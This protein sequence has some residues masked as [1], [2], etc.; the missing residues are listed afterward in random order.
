MTGLQIAHYR[1]DKLIGRGGMGEV[2]LAYDLRLDRPVAIKVLPERKRDSDPAVS[3]FLREAKAASALNHPNIVTIHEV[4]ETE[5]GGHFMVQELVDGE[6][7]RVR[8]R[9][10]KKLALDAV[11]DIGR[12]TARALTAAHAHGII[13]RDIKPENLMV[14]RDGYVKVLDFGLARVTTTEATRDGESEFGT[15]PG[16]ILGT[17]AYMSPEQ[18]RGEP[19]DAASDIFTLGILLYEIATGHRPFSVESG[20]AQLHAIVRL[21]PLAPSRHN[22]E[23]PTTFDGLILRMLAKDKAMRPTADEVARELDAL[24]GQDRP[25]AAATAVAARRRTVGREKERDALRHAFAEMTA[26][27]GC[28]AALAG[29]PGIGKTS[30]AEDF[31]AEIAAGPHHPVIARG[32]CSERLAGTE[33]YMPILEALDNLIHGGSGEAFTS[34]L[35]QTAPVWFVQVAPLSTESTTALQ[36]HEDV[37]SASQERMKRELGVLLQEISRVRPVVLFLEDLHWA[38][39]S[40]IDVLNYLGGRLSGMRVMVLVTYRPSEMMLA[41]HPYL[42]IRSDLEASGVLRDLPL[43]FLTR[44]DVDHYL[45]LEFPE[46]RFVPDFGALVYS[47]TEGSPLFMVDLLRYL[48]DRGA[49]IQNDGRW[50]LA[51]SIAE[52]E[53]ELPDSVRATIERKIERLDERDRKL[54]VAAAVQGHEFDSAIVAD[55][56]GADPADVEEQLDDLVRV[57]AMIRKVEDREL[58]DHTL[59]VRC[60]FVHVLYQ[61][62]LYASLQPTRR[63]SLS[64]KVA[65]SMVTHAGDKDRALASELAMLFETARNFPR[66]AACFFEAAQHAAGL[67]AFPEAVVLARRGLD[68]VKM[69][70][71]GAPRE[72]QELG[73]LMVLGLS[74]R[75][76]EGWAATE[77]E[78]IYT[79]CRNICQ[80]LGN[81]PQLFPAMWGLT[82]FYAIR[83]DL[84]VFKPYAEQLLRQAEEIGSDV[85][86]VG[87]HQMVASVNEFL[88]NTITSSEHFE[89]AVRRYVPQQGPLYTATYGLDPGVIALGLSPRPLWFRGLAD[90]AMHRIE[91]TVATARR[92]HQPIS[93]VFAVC[94]ASNIRLLR[95]EP[96]AAIAH[97]DDEIALCREYGLAQELE[98]GRCFRGL[99]LA[100]VGRLDEAVAELRDS[101]QTQRRISTGLLRG[102]WLTFLADVLCRA[103][104]VEEGL[105]AVDEAVEHAERTLERFYMAETHRVRGQLLLGRDDDAARESFEAAL[106][107]AA[108]QGAPAFELRAAMDLHRLAERGSPD[109]RGRSH[110]RLAAIF[111]RFTE[112]FETGDLLRARALLQS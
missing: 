84:R 39:V 58:P 18:A 59:S 79:R 93:L 97:A 28:F 81:P 1:I 33:A 77:L 14:R 106:T 54:L 41:R 76:V 69:M 3:R 73:L 53:R 6:T 99:A 12:Q 108:S 83:G 57:H 65:Q 91:D 86:L 67:F 105:A 80:E 98:W 109:D 17:G 92:L 74:L 61:N 10:E 49:L 101:L 70:P 21:H 102:M 66:A 34:V 47:R 31:L 24:L 63:A 96:E 51:R 25:T 32:K 20:L 100:H 112:G 89:E 23:L 94:L 35:K 7:V 103:G 15:N 55:A 43:E 95:G 8:L 82:M 46:H 44:D 29:E 111:A 9:R 5:Q 2:Y 78:K 107:F 64:G 90:Q 60:R 40:T 52:I 4:G 71:D 13:H 104:A 19:V 45:A 72:Q 36:M 48:R 50:E 42:R 37:K 56:I 75:S 110:A 11:A 26:E 38:D 87:A 27:Q 68:M 16:V 30:L 62:A 88:G 22:P 85:F